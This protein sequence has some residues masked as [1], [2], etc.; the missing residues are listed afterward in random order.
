MKIGLAQ[1]DGKWPNLALAKLAAWHREHGDEVSIFDPLF[2]PY[3][4][5]FAS[6]VFRE[7]PDNPYLPW[8]VRIGGTG[9]DPF[10]ELGGGTEEARPDWSL[11][12]WWKKDMG[13]STRGCVRRCGFCIVPVK[14]GRIRI[15]AEFGD[16]ST[17][18]SD[19]ILLDN[20]LTAAPIEHFRAV[21]RDATKA[22]VRIVFSQGLDARLLTDEHAAIL[23]RTKTE[24][25]IRMAF[26][27]V[28]DEEAVRAAVNRM[29][30]AGW[31]A[32]RLMFF[33]LIGF[34]STPEEDMYRV[35]VVRSLGADPFVMKYNRHDA[36]QTRFARW[37]NNVVAF[38]AMTWAEWQK[39][40]K[41]RL[42][43]TE[44]T[45]NPVAT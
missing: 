39:S 2:G 42:P 27:H 26:D 37:V 3:D 29:Q 35:E 30:A 9:Y 45:P 21:C 16:L 6:K 34:D 13:F 43:D 10:I 38:N 4:R 24:K 15:V 14:E 1:V 7:T 25:T 23:R 44:S 32:S 36:Y 40:F 18:R 8:D 19:L 20:N 17:G 12:P 31:P 11:W 41:S 33:V 28:R 22:G 5:V